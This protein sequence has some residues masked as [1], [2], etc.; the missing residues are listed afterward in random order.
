MKTNEIIKNR[1]LELNLTLKEVANALG[2]AESTV[3]RY[4]SNSIQHIRVDKIISLAQVLK[5]SPAYLLGYADTSDEYNHDPIFKEFY[6]EGYTK[7]ELEKIREYAQFIKAGRSYEKNKDAPHFT[8]VAEATEYLKRH[9]MIA[10]FNGKTTYTDETILQL[11]N[12]LY[13]EN[14]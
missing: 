5:C 4:E 7:E 13:K 1:R 14:R 8:N 3:S 2:T 12:V 6:T 10:A 11:A 9:Q